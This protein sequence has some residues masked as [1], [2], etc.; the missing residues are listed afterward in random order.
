MPRTLPDLLISYQLPLPE[1]AVRPFIDAVDAPGL[2][3]SVEPRQPSGPFA[4]F[5]WLL[6]TAVFIW[7]GKSYFDGFLKEAGKDHY[8]L[9][10]RGLSLLWPVFFGESRGVRVTAV[11]TPGKIRP[12][13]AKYSLGISILAEADSGLHFKLL[14]PDDISA[15][16]FNVATASFLGFLERY[17]AGA[18]D[19][20]TE[21]QLSSARVLG[22]T[23]LVTYDQVQGLFRF[24]DPI[25][26][27]ADAGK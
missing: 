2:D 10:K 20:A 4:G 12:D 19:V 27:D 9:V 6:P 23:I 16:G 8:L 14:F 22:K 24:L 7:F 5:Q 11:G 25:P 15:E 18:L 17:Y 13:E 1:E 21:L 3:L 26:K